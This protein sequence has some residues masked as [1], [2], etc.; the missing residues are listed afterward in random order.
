MNKE[1]L[2]LSPTEESLAFLEFDLPT[3]NTS[4]TRFEVCLKM[5]NNI[6]FEDLTLLLSSSISSITKCFKMFPS[7]LVAIS[8]FLLE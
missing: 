8:I 2:N 4:S 3:G 6:K 7:S 1:I 5:I